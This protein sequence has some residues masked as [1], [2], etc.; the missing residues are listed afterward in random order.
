MF[1]RCEFL[2]W[3]FLKWWLCGIALASLLLLGFGTIISALSPVKASSIVAPAG[4]GLMGGNFVLGTVGASSTGYFSWNS[5]T[6]SGIENQR[7]WYIGRAATVR[8]FYI[9]TNN[10][11]PASGALV[12][13]LRKNGSDQ[14]VTITI[15]AGSAAGSFSD[16]SNSFQVAA[17]DLLTIK[18]VNSATSTSA[19]LL[20][21]GIGLQ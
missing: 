6:N 13:T 14:S 5:T 18:A 8:N 1:W 16:T 20:A 2:R 4:G 21:W 15:A 17:G 9:L 10:A 19:Q 3:E 11:Q 12:L 7:Q